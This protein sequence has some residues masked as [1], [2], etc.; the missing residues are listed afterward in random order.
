MNKI[1]VLV[2]DDQLLICDGIRIILDSQPDIQVIRTVDNG[3]AAVESAMVDQ[4]DVV[5]MDIQM[6]EMS[7][8][9]ALKAIKAKRPQTV[10]LMLTTFAPDEYILDSFRNGADG[11]LIKDLSGERLAMAIRNAFAGNSTMPVSIAAR[12]LAQIPKDIVKK[13]LADYGLTAREAKV[14]ELLAQGYLNE[15]ISQ[16]LGISLGTVKN[17]IS[18]IYQKL[19]VDNR[20]QAILLMTALKKEVPQ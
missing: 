16:V 8:I 1:R 18:N 10:V 3:R 15:S 2:A 6:P 11:Y 20:R 14:A 7:G 17:Y 9:D 12:L 5:L 4:P 13:S 19:E